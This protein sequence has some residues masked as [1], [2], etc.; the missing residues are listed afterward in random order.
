M[1]HSDL[2]QN[3]YIEDQN[4]IPGVVHAGVESYLVLLRGAVHFYQHLE[5][6]LIEIMLGSKGAAFD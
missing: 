4:Y 6:E 2:A 1:C 5:V 3:K